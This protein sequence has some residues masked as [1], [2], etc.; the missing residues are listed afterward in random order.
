MNKNEIDPKEL[1]GEALFWYFTENEDYHDE[2]YSSIVK[3]LPMATAWDFEEVYKIL[4]ECVK[5]D[6]KLVAVYPGVDESPVDAN[7]LKYIGEIYDGALY[8]TI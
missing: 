6:K 7:K 8:I 5:E 3:L 1:S 4:E 2:D